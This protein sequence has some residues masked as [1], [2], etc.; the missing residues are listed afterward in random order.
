MRCKYCQGLSIERLVELAE[1]EFKATAFPQNAYYTHQPT[2]AALDTSAE[3]GCDLCQLIVQALE[4]TSDNAS[5][6]EELL[7][8]NR[9][10]DS[11]I[12]ATARGLADFYDTAIRICI[13]TMHVIWG[14]SLSDVEML[15]MLLIQVGLPRSEDDML[16]DDD[17]DYAIAQ[18]GL[19]PA[20]PIDDS[21]W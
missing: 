6:A 11:I 14:T 20:D 16:S 10:Q 18:P 7:G 2:I 15:E 4:S 9:T 21:T 13:N 12:L 19:H 8:L 17:E 5:W 1:T 3:Q